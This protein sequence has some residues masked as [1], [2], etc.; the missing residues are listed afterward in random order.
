MHATISALP[1]PQSLTG[2]SDVVTTTTQSN[3]PEPEAESVAEAEAEAEA[4]PAADAESEA[5]AESG[6][7]ESEAEAESVGTSNSTAGGVVKD[8]GEAEPEPEPEGGGANQTTKDLRVRVQHQQ[9]LPPLYDQIKPGQPTT[10]TPHD[11][12]RRRFTPNV[13]G[14]PRVSGAA[15]RA[16][17]QWQ[18]YQNYLRNL[19]SWGT[20]AQKQ[21]SQFKK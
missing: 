18:K 19:Q 14:I 6:T 15:A 7:A 1:L 3:H 5:E 17:A 8:D 11:L 16:A 4:E 12:H 2:G 13:F 21:F 20:H 9:T 10:E